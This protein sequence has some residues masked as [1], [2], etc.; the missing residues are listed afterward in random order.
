M[1]AQARNAETPDKAHEF[2]IRAKL[3][4]LLANGPP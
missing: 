4:R 2:A 1:E 3:F